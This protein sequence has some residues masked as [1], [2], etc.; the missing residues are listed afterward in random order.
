[1]RILAQAKCFGMAASACEIGNDAAQMYSVSSL[2]CWAGLAL[3]IFLDHDRS[4]H[5]SWCSCS[6]PM[7]GII[8]RHAET[9]GNDSYTGAPTARKTRSRWGLVSPWVHRCRFRVST[10]SNTGIRGYPDDRRLEW[11]MRQREPAHP[12]RPNR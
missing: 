4:T 9:R 12:K 8:V 11:L 1:M 10:G 5:S 3:R 7:R 6:E 2:S